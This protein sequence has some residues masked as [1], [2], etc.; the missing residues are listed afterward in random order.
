[1][2]VLVLYNPNFILYLNRNHL[3]NN[4]QIQEGESELQMH[5]VLIYSQ[6][7]AC[8]YDCR[9][10]SEVLSWIGLIVIFFFFFLQDR[11]P[12]EWIRDSIFFFLTY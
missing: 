3:K 5:F 7:D 10:I 2:Q 8:F 12:L 1:M 9:T 4:C 11:D 6:T